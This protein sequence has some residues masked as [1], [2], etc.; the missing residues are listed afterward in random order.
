MLLTAGAAGAAPASLLLGLTELEPGKPLL[1]IE[2]QL[3]LVV[4]AGH[5]LVPLLHDTQ[6]ASH[7]LD[8]DVV[9]VE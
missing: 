4:E 8:G 3:A 7:L 1:F 6:P 5:Q 2:K 9:D